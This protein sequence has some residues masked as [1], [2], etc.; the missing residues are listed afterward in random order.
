MKNCKLI[1]FGLLM[2][3]WTSCTNDAVKDKKDIPSVETKNQQVI[4]SFNGD[5]AYNYVA[6]QVAFGPR[7]P[8]SKAHENCA[9]W[10]QKKMELFGAKVTIQN[11]KARAYTGKI[12]SGSNIIATF[13]PDAQKRIMLSSHWDS[14]PFADHDPDPK[15]HYIPIDGANDGASGVGIL[16]EMARQFQ[17]QNP[18]VGVDILFWDLEDYGEHNDEVKTGTDDFWGLGSQYWSK[19]N[20]IPGYSASFGILLDMVG[21]ENPSFTKEAYSLNYAAGIVAKVWTAARKLGYQDIF[22][23]VEAGAVTDDHYYVN[24][25]SNIPTIDII[26]YDTGEK[27]GFFPYWHTTGDNMSHISKSTL[28]VVGQTLMQVIYTE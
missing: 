12:L 15:K 18:K 19:N 16:L 6:K 17:M 9:L 24:K 10:L 20:H 7:I 21:A 2:L 14:R 1:F 3:L 8:S 4:A 11:F 28:K 22:R 23:D 25:F 5:S 13:N 27:N 26:H